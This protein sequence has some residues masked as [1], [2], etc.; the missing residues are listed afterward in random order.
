MNGNDQGRRS[1][2]RGFML[3]AGLGLAATAWAADGAETRDGT[4]SADPRGDSRFNVRDFGAT[5]DGRTP[6]SA[7]IQRA[8]DAAGAVQGQVWFPAGRYRCHDLKAPPHVTLLGTSAWEFKPEKIGSVLE[9]DDPK[10]KCLLNVTGAFG[11]RMRGL[12][13]FGIRSTPRPVH[14]ILLDQAAYSPKEDTLVF[15]DNKV[16]NFSGH[17]IYLNRVCLFILRHSICGRNGGDGC[18]IRGWDG[19]VLDNQFSG[20]AG[21]GFGCEDQ[22]ST[23]TFTANR[24]EWNRGNGLQ[25]GFGNNWNVTGNAFDGNFGAGLAAYGTYAITVTGNVFRRSGRDRE[26]HDAGKDTC[27]ARLDGLRGLAMTGNSCRAWGGDGAPTAEWYYTPRVGFVV[28]NLAYSVISGNALHE[29]YTKTKILDLGG[30]GK[31]LVMKD[32]VG[33]P[34]VPPKA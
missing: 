12:T 1:T 33:C 27:Q 10:A 7:A 34:L 21:N 31:E 22:C 3:G 4:P 17:G 23:V 6:D 20:N 14:G 2:R 15:E 5:G 16:T 13:L 24:V 28:R 18:R 11:V 25:I 26:A 8:L 29:G 30:H 9:L 19:F 32:N